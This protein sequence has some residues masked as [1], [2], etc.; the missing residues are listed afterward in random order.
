ML[1]RADDLPSLD[2]ILAQLPTMVNPLGVKGAG[3]AGC[4]AVPQ[5]ITNAIRHHRS[6]RTM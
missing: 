4:I 1:C 5:T 6:N 2:V 3:Q